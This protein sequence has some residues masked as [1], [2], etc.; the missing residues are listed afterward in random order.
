MEKEINELMPAWLEKLNEEEAAFS[1]KLRGTNLSELSPGELEALAADCPPS[2]SY[3]IKLL[4]GL[5]NHKKECLAAKT[6]AANKVETAALEGWRED[7][8]TGLQNYLWS[9]TLAAPFSQQAKQNLLAYVSIAPLA[10]VGLTI[11]EILD[12]TSLT[13]ILP[14]KLGGLSM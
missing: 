11:Q 9:L 12:S 3:L 4:L 6:F 1:K 14:R 8:E 2:L 13:P 10:G 7:G 5:A